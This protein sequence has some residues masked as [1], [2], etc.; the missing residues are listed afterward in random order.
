MIGLS[1]GTLLF[2]V[3][4]IVVVCCVKVQTGCCAHCKAG[5]FIFLLMLFVIITCQTLGTVI[6]YIWVNDSYGVTGSGGYT[7]MGQLSAEA[8]K[9]RSGSEGI[10]KMLDKSMV[11]IVST[12]RLYLIG[13]CA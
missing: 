12:A 7:T 13:S 6:A 4:G 5:L 2:A 10:D 9:K 3:F 11:Q 8:E 1:V